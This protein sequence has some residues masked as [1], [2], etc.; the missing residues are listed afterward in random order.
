MPD[1]IFRLPLTITDAQRIAIDGYNDSLV[2]TGGPGSG[3]TTVTI[4]R[5]LNPVKNNQDVLLFTYNRTLLAA[6]KGI[7]RNKSEELFGELDETAINSVIQNKV[8]SFHKWYAQGGQWFNTSLD[9]HQI[10]QRFQQVGRKYSEIFFDEAQDLTPA[11]YAKAFVLADKITCGADNAQDLQGNFP[12]DEALSIILEKLNTQ[13]PTDLQP[14]TA[15]FRNTKEIFEFAR[16]FVPDDENVQNIDTS[17]LPNGEKPELFENLSA[18]NQLEKIK[19]IIE[20]NPMNNIG[21][22][23]NYSNQV[24][25]IKNYLETNNYSCRADAPNDKTFSYYFSGMPDSDELVMF[26]RMKTPFICTYDSCKGLEF[27]IVIMPFF[28]GAEIALTTRKPKKIKNNN[29]FL[30]NATDQNGNIIYERNADSTIQMWATRNHYYVGATRARIQLYIMC[31]NKP[32]LLS[33][34]N[35]NDEVNLLNDDLPF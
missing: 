20:A 19:E 12:P 14:L 22:L 9:E 31:F 30:V 15:N 16:G 3:K 2:V 29:G 34:F 23:V 10:E 7:L 17:E 35:T 24:T 25:D 18:E 27:D 26:D 13:S 5:F 11:V 33:F 6:I 28:S 8:N 21:I 4:F 1:F 32:K